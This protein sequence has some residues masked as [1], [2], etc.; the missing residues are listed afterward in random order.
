MLRSALGTYTSH[1]RIS[2]R[3]AALGS[4]YALF[5]GL[6]FS[7]VVVVELLENLGYLDFYAPAGTVRLSLQEPVRD[8][9]APVHNTCLN[10]FEALEALDY[11]CGYTNGAGK[12]VSPCRRNDDGSCE[13]PWRTFHNYDCQYL[14]G[15]QAGLVHES[16]ILIATFVHATEQA[17]NASC[18]DTVR[19]CDKLWVS[20][21]STQRFVTDIERFTLLLDH[22]VQQPDL[23]VRETARDMDGYLVVNGSRASQ[24]ELCATSPRA[25]LLPPTTP[26]ERLSRHR[27]PP[28]SRPDGAPCAIEPRQPSGVAGLDV[29]SVGELLMAAGVS[30]DDESFAGSGHSG[31]FEGLSMSV[32]IKYSNSAPWFGLRGRVSYSYHVDAIPT[33]AYKQREQ[34]WTEHPTRRTLVSKHGIYMEVLQGGQLAGFSFTSMLLRLTTS[35]A[36]LA[37]AT[38]I[39]DVLACFVLDKS[40]L[41]ASLIYE[42][43]DV[44]A[45]APVPG[46]AEGS[47][48]APSVPGT[49]AGAGRRPPPPPAARQRPPGEETPLLRP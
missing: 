1:K 35:M 27:H 5:A 26:L 11:C 29:Y 10:D 17:R 43:A 45:A 25:I 41:Y 48:R 13:C 4:L 21:R 14:D 24:H 34:V 19:H 47:G 23:G 37:V 28:P 6:I 18:P 44:A 38:S 7:Y 3:S 20:G 33:N 42:D 36:L 16:S 40:A 46:G 9:C 32:L 12:Y 31:R 49:L 39:V 30:L 15:S 8:G 22:S 2:I